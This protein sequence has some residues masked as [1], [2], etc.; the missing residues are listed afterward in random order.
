MVL[1]RYQLGAVYLETFPYKVWDKDIANIVL[2]EMRA[3]IHWIKSIKWTP[4][5]TN[6]DFVKYL[7][8][9]GKLYITDRADKEYII[10]KDD[11]LMGINKIL[12][13]KEYGDYVKNTKNILF[14]KDM[15]NIAVCDLI[16]QMT[17]LGEIIYQ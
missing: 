11:I 9:D 8:N 3:S 13:D 4:T 14:M 6:C 15:Y 1:R 2:G 5:R 7:M 12:K 17:I 10:T 16:M